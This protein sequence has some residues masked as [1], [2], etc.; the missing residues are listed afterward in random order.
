MEFEGS[1]GIVRATLTFEGIEVFKCTF[2]SSCTAE[3]INTA[4]GEAC[5]A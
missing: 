5:A 2:P 1:N 4:Y 3:M